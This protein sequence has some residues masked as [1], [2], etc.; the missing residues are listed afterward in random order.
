MASKTNE[1]GNKFI[2]A[3]SLLTER[4]G[5]ASRTGK[6][7]AGARDLYT[8]L[9]YTQDPTVNDFLAQY[10]FNGV[11]SRIIKAFPSATWRDT[12]SVTDDAGDQTETA[13]EKAVLAL[14]KR[15]NLYRL[16]ERA[17]R[18]ASI[19]QYGVI[20]LG[21]SGADDF[22]KEVTGNRTLLYL[23]AYGESKC[24][25]TEWE[26][27]PS[28]KR[29]GL[30]K[31][32]QIRL[33]MPGGSSK[34]MTVHHSRIVHIAEGALEN[35]V[36]GEPRLRPIYNLLQD[37]IKVV[38]GGAEMFWRGAAPGL[39]FDIAKDV[40]T[41]S[42]DQLESLKSSIDDY[43]HGLSRVLRTQGVEVNEL[44]KPTQD[45]TGMASMILDL[46]AGTTGIPK[47]ILIGSERGE[48]ASSQDQENWESRIVERQTTFAEPCILRPML[49]R[50][51]AVGA[52]PKP[53]GGEYQIEWP[54]RLAMS[55][56]DKAQIGL[57]IAQGANVLIPGGAE[58]VITREEWRERIGLDPV[59]DGG[60]RDAEEEEPIDENDPAFTDDKDVPEAV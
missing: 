10:H 50:L 1:S 49:D 2:H 20:L 45:G 28:N 32:Y 26:S 21:F 54:D 57:T 30:P 31:L 18:L 23:Q 11:A 58:S 13:F 60:F 4:I 8:V 24:A 17:D 29:F 46:I 6:T 16:L 55:I 48:L 5:V 38:G 25:I 59:P 47:R 56:L 19:G 40:P 22:D 41:P 15:V 34:T 9:G 44:G 52:L 51:I 33:D 39:H 14:D 27:D 42:E 43:I 12:P 36:Y 37:I 35:D 53:A 7:Y 3:L